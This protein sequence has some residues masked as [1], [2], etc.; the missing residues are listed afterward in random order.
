MRG[1]RKF[2]QSYKS[3]KF[4]HQYTKGADQTSQMCRPVCAFV[5]SM[6]LSHFSRDSFNDYANVIWIINK[7]GFFQKKAGGCLS[8]SLYMYSCTP[9]ASILNFSR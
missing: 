9:V 1:S 7:Y 4:C 3:R 2:C 5:V 8:L 6:Q